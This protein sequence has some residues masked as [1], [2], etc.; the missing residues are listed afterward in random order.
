LRPGRRAEPD[1]YETELNQTALSWIGR[2]KEC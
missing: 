1:L 2:C